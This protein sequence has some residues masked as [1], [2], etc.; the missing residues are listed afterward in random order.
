MNTAELKKRISEVLGVSS[1]QSEIAYEIFLEKLSKFLSYGITLKVPRVGFFQLKES[2][3]DNPRQILFASL[4]ED[5]SATSK[6]F[7][8]TLDV[9]NNSKNNF[10]IDSQVFSIGVGK[11]LLPLINEDTEHESEISFE[12]LKKSIEERTKELL[13]ESDQ[14]PNYNIWDEFLYEDNDENL[15]DN[16][17]ATHEIVIENQIES[18]ENIIDKLL[19]QTDFT[20]ENDFN[21]VDQGEIINQEIN[22]ETNNLD[23]TIPDDISINSLLDEEIEIDEKNEIEQENIE[24][25]LTDLEVSNSNDTNEKLK[26]ISSFAEELKNQIDE[27]KKISNE[28]IGEESAIEN[29]EKEN[30]DNSIIKMENIDLSSQQE[31]TNIETSSEPVVESESLNQTNEDELNLSNLLDDDERIINNQIKIEPPASSKELIIDEYFIP[32]NGIINIE[33]NE[34]KQIVQNEIDNLDKNHNEENN[35]DVLNKLLTEEQL[36]KIDINENEIDNEV[37][38][39]S[40]EETVSNKIEWNWG[41]ELKEE[42][43]LGN[44]ES[45]EFQESQETIQEIK[46]ETK[47]I[48]EEISDNYEDTP[49]TELRKTRVDLFTKLEETLEREISF[50]KQE[51]ENKEEEIHFEKPEVKEDFIE[52]VLDSKNENKNSTNDIEFKDEKVILDFKTPPPQY[53]F[54]E[55]RP[56]ENRTSKENEVEPLLKP[57]KKITIILSPEEQENLIEKKTITK[58]L[59]NSETE[60][61]IIQK[62]TEKKNYLKIISI[63]LASAIVLTVSIFFVLKF[64]MSNKGEIKEGINNKSNNTQSF[65]TE[66]PKNEINPNQ[67]ISVTENQTQNTTDALSIDEYS[68]FPIT[69]T[70]P[71]PIKSGNEINVEQLIPNAKKVE[72]KIITPVEK[73]NEVQNVA[74]NKN[75]TQEKKSPIGNKT[76]E[77]IKTQNEVRL[78]NMVFFDGKNYSFQTSSWKNKSLA[79]IEMNRLRTLG[80]NAFISEAYLP[81]KGGKWYRVRI[82]YFSSEQE[83]LDFKKKNNF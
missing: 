19:E 39:S 47:L 24:T 33:E 38:I 6:N 5:Y 80:F 63:V 81:Q 4:P 82:G 21:E 36:K 70:P 10:E 13:S 64:I 46:K 1:T 9:Q 69:A 27:L 41:D 53:E 43:G 59:E 55:E 49:T 65:K 44:L 71:K 16:D 20:I 17:S 45:I 66:K 40:T 34:L 12:M 48:E 52:E 68:D 2:Y 78:S 15:F 37:E 74:L 58:T 60:V 35:S 73:K 56:V 11:P 79:E 51:V 83:A 32:Q 77:K 8:L 76:A 61:E 31:E 75:Q 42:F 57:P 30:D 50:L 28:I 22:E 25:S 29:K 14:I 7:Y 62:P 18:N 67:N 72:T 54:I 23:I 3:N 26:Q